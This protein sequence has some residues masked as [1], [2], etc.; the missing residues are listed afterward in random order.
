MAAK[1]KGLRFSKCLKCFVFENMCSKSEMQNE[2]K[3]AEF[4]AAFKIVDF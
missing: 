4:S 1:T 3:N 2:Y